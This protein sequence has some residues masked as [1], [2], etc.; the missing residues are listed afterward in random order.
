MKRNGSSFAIE[1]ALYTRSMHNECLKILTDSFVSNPLHERA[2]GKE[3]HTRNWSFFSVGLRSFRGPRYVAL[4]DNKIVGFVHWVH[5]S[6]CQF[7]F[8]EKMSALPTMINTLGLP[9]TINVSRW[10]RSWEKCDLQG[11][12]LHLGPIAV[13]QSMKGLGIGSLLM[14]HYCA[15]A[16]LLN[17]NGYLE[18]D[19]S[20]NVSFYERF[21]FAVIYEEPVLGVKNFFMVRKPQRFRVR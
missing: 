16:D 7:S 9:A 5:S 20:E 21:N 8:L 3:V 1:I 12:H 10:L 2:F 11:E 4:M 19:K 15:E 14:H 6:K 17:L 13:A 18:T